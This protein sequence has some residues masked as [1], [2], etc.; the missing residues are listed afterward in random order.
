MDSITLTAITLRGQG[1][2][3]FVNEGGQ[4]V[5]MSRLDSV[6]DVPAFFNNKG[7]CLL[8]LLDSK[9]TGTGEA[10]IVNGGGALRP[11][12]QNRRLQDRREKRNRD[13]AK[14]S[15]PRCR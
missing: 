10:A 5:S 7:Q 1:K 4:C 9:L 13:Q 2:Y 15:R 12:S 11:Q 6:N 8:T 3:G 14:C